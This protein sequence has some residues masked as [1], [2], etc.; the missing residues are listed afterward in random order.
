MNKPIVCIGGSLVDETFYCLQPP[1]KGTSNPAQ[2]ELSAGGVVRNI[3]HHLALL[4][5]QVQLITILGNDKEGDWLNEQCTRAG[6]DM[7][8]IIRMDGVTGRFT[9]VLGTDGELFVGTVVNDLEPLLNSELLSIKSDALKQA[10]LIITDTNMNPDCI[11]WLIQFCSDHKIPCIIEPVS[12]P[13]AKKLAAMD[14][15]DL[16]LITPNEV[17]LSAIQS[18]ASEPGVKGMINALLN[19][20]VQQ[21]WLRQGE[22]GSTIYHSNQQFSLHAPA[23]NVID[24][25]GAGDAALAGWIHGFVHEKSTEDKIRY[26]HTLAALVL[27]QKGTIVKGLTAIKLEEEV[28]RLFPN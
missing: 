17:E 2:L 11:Q 23:V 27:Q 28:N 3:A 25:T 8:H 18:V 9:A 24:T 16:F 14:L 19:R 12:I 7:Q 13:K 1:I 10:G 20:G 5:H 15:S 22:N 21:V 6:I 4:H 26:G